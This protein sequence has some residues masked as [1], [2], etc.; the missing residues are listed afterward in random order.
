MN[1]KFELVIAQSVV[2]LNDF[3]F[4]SGIVEGLNEAM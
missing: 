2:L 3:R 4:S 1:S